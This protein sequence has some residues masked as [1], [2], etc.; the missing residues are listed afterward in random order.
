MDLRGPKGGGCCRR[1]LFV[2]L[3]AEGAWGRT[4]VAGIADLVLQ[5]G[6]GLGPVSPAVVRRDRTHLTTSV[7]KL[8][9]PGRGSYDAWSR[10]MRWPV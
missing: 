4:R 3:D 8:A 1:Q 10:D 9:T 5:M 7:P 2:R 6:R